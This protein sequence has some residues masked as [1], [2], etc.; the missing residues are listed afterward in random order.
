MKRYGISIDHHDGKAWTHWTSSVHHCWTEAEALASAVNSIERCVR[1]PHDP[2]PVGQY[3]VQIRLAG[4]D[5]R[6]I[7]AG[8]GSLGLVA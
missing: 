3:R 6:Q 7:V 5:V 8:F 2:W 4:Q 1:N